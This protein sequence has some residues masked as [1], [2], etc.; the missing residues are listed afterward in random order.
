MKEIYGKNN[1]L[2]NLWDLLRLYL[3]L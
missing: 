1:K 3:H 2:A